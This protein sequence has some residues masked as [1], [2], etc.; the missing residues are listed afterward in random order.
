MD[1]ADLGIYT[2]IIVGL[3]I[4]FGIGTYSEFRNMNN[5]EYKGTERVDD[6]DTFKAFLKKLFR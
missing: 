3:F 2:I 1:D 5:R 6:G 4:M